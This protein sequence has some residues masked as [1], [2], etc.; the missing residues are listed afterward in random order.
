MDFL[1]ISKRI[2]SIFIAVTLVVSLCSVSIGH[3]ATYPNSILAY[4]VDVSSWQYDIDWKKVKAD[5]IDFAILRVGT[6]KGKDT[7]FEQNYKNAKAAG[8]ELG[9]YFYTYADTVEEAEADAEMVLNWLDEKQFE[10]PIYYDM[11]DSVQLASGMTTKLRTKMCEAFCDKLKEENWCVGIYSNANW[12]KNYLDESTLSSKYEMWLASWRDSG[13]PEKDYSDKYGMWQYTNVGKV[14]GISTNVDRNVV[15]REYP[16]IIKNG[17]YNGYAA[18]EIEEVNEEWIITSSNGVKVREGAGT[19]YKQIGSL[20]YNERIH[21]T[22]KVYGRTYTWGRITLSDG[23]IGWSVLNYAKKTNSTLQSV[24]KKISVENNLIL[25]AER[26]TIITEDMF[27]VSG[28]AQI[29][30]PKAINCGTGQAVELT[31]GGDTVNTYYVV[32]RGDINGDSYIDAYD[33]SHSTSVSNMDTSYDKKSPQYYALDVN[34]D[35]VCDIYDTQLIELMSI[36]EK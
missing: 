30:M 11:E 6:T 2:I 3:A 36:E 14:D 20:A 5:G 4:G 24:D 25:G 23:R 22:G 17:G 15:Y 27:K 13:N 12:L 32:I 26:G 18:A 19:S 9:A 35:G 10:Y 16:E 1:K 33:V 29:K 28:L 31:L 34:K 8:I 7:Y 21:V